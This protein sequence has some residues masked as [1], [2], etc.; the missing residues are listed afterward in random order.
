MIIINE[1]ENWLEKLLDDLKTYGLTPVKSTK[2]YHKFNYLGR[3][4]K[5]WFYN[6]F[7]ISSQNYFINSFINKKPK[8]I[9]EFD[10]EDF[11]KRVEEL[12]EKAKERK[13]IKNVLGVT[14]MFI[15]SELLELLEQTHESYKYISSENLL[16]VNKSLSIKFS[17]YDQE[18]SL[19][20][21]S[22]YT[23]K[24]LQDKDLK[25][26]KWD[27]RNPNKGYPNL[28]K[29]DKFISIIEFLKSLSE[30]YEEVTKKIN[31]EENIKQIRQEKINIIE[32]EIGD[33]KELLRKKERDLRTLK[34]E[35][36]SIKNIKKNWFES[37]TK[38]P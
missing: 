21:W 5:V 31:D 28:L 18:L 20:F 7:S 26:M 6:G 34:S 33:I 30:G 27:L 10:V 22:P 15:E 12:S 16:N 24:K 3:E 38:T 19:N 25:E 23:Y 32:K 4:F 9:T 8:D 36:K 14:N 35:Q 17:I 13:E 1:K 11:K 2:H 37:A 29:T